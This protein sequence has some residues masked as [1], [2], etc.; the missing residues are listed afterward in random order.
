MVLGNLNLFSH[1]YMH[2]MESM[3]R[4]TALLEIEKNCV[5]IETKEAIFLSTRGRSLIDGRLFFRASPIS[6]Y[7]SRAW[8]F[9]CLAFCSTDYRKKRDCS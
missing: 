8:P 4:V 7:Q 9:A 6:R 2:F 5:N 1:S 3:C